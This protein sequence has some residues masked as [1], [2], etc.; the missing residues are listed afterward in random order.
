[1]VLPRHAVSWSL[2]NQ[3]MVWT[4]QGRPG[5]KLAYQGSGLAI[6]WPCHRLP[7]CSGLA[8]AWTGLS[9]G[10]PGHWLAWAWV[11]RSLVWTR[12]G[13]VMVLPSHGLAWL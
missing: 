4:V 1:M 7:G 11:V 5:H 6:W 8:M 10:L 12:S 9:K 3:A 13:L 2:A